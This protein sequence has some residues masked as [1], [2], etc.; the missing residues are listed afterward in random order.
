MSFGVVLCPRCGV[1]R[2]V[3]LESKTASCPN[4]G[5]R[6]K[7]KGSRIL[8]TLDN[9]KEV[10]QA[11]REINTK[12]RGGEEIYANDLKIL[13]KKRKGS[14]NG[15]SPNLYDEVAG[16]LVKIKGKDKKIV[17]CA[18]QLCSIQVEFTEDDFIEVLKRTGLDKGEECEKYLKDLIADDVIYQPRNGVYRCLEDI[19]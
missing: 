16:K 6:M 18:R 13:E 2:G 8:A 10:A 12:L 14:Y 19:D 17:A 9:E 15:K 7:L 11:V 4:C 1:A 3:K 5:T